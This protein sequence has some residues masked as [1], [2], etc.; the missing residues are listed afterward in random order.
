M[1]RLATTCFVLAVMAVSSVNAGESCG[2]SGYNPPVYHSGHHQHHAA[3]HHG[4]HGVQLGISGS[5]THCGFQIDAVDCHTI[6]E[7]L[8][9]EAGDVI[10]SINGRR[11]DCRTALR[12]ALQDVAATGHISM[13]VED[14]RLYRTVTVSGRLYDSVPTVSLR[15]NASQ[16]F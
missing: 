3:S 13:R 5:F 11:I 10:L 4:V 15:T 14:A 9:L 12:R 1:I 7:Q 2:L 6:G 16:R 8:G